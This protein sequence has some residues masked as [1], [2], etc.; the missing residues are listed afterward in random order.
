[1]AET[2]MAETDSPE[3]EGTTGEAERFSG[4]KVITLS[5]AHLLHDT[6]GSFLAPLLPLLTAKLGMSLSVSAFLD[7]TRRVPTLFNPI[8]GM[9]AEYRGIKLLV[10]L[11]PAVTS[12][13]MS[14]TG[15]W[16]LPFPYSSCSYSLQGSLQPSFT[17]PLPYSCA[18]PP[19]IRWVRG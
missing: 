6:F 18:S 15:L 12:T 5:V 10:I 19:A 2:K 3:E 8:F 4:S 14:L 11:T 16:H 1:M 13:A 17:S 9:I 7:I